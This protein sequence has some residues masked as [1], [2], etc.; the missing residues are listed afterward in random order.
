MR[1]MWKVGVL[2]RGRFLPSSSSSG[3]MR[4]ATLSSGK[5]SQMRSLLTGRFIRRSATALTKARRCFFSRAE[6]ENRSQ[7]ASQVEQ[8][9]HLDGSHTMLL[10]GGALSFSLVQQVAKCRQEWKLDNSFFTHLSQ[11]VKLIIK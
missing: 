11:I 6:R 4:L 1:D 9:S 3:V 5:K 2:K 10:G 7:R 8:V